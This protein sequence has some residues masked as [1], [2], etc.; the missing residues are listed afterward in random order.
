M[1]REQAAEIQRH[2]LT[3][4]KAI[5][6]V[7]ALVFDLD[8]VEDRKAFAEQIGNAYEALQHEMLDQVIYRQFPDLRPPSKEKPRIDSKLT[9]DKVSLPPSL[10]VMD[11]D[12]VILSTLSRQWHK[13]ARIVGNVSEH[14]RGLGVDLDPAIAA[15][16]L[17]TMVES[18]LVEGAGDLRKWRF[19]EVRVK[20]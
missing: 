15:A 19:S 2:L 1:T 16:R 4:K 10:T 14:Y 12:R 3:A 6:R 11:F 8:E 13:T 7:A 20:S 18:G 17:M 5:N 9:W